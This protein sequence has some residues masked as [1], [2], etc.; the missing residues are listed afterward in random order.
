[1]FIIQYLCYP[2]SD[3]HKVPSSIWPEHQQ[4]CNMKLGN[5]QMQFVFCFKNR[6]QNISR[7]KTWNCYINCLSEQNF[8][9]TSQTMSVLI[10]NPRCSGHCGSSTGCK[11]KIQKENKSPLAWNLGK[12]SQRN[13]KQ[14]GYFLNLKV[15]PTEAKTMAR[16]R[17]RKPCQRMKEMAS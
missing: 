14:K 11:C 10:R 4:H 3:L 2:P 9:V 8:R 5:I 12:P 15:C 6:E 7:K 13:K 17:G 1:M 16:A